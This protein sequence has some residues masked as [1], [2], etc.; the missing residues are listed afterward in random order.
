M[1][2]VGALGEL[3]FATLRCCHAIAIEMDFVLSARWLIRSQCGLWILCLIPSN[4]I[5]DKPGGTGPALELRSALHR[6]LILKNLFAVDRIDRQ[7]CILSVT[8]TFL[9]VVAQMVAWRSIS[10]GH[11]QCIA[12][13]SFFDEF[14]AFRSLRI[15]S[16]IIL[17]DAISLFAS[18]I[19][20]QRGGMSVC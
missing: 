2:R 18:G 8:D 4:D 7:F 11:R 9:L 20:S 12:L 13:E 15:H 10:P 1:L 14:S 6:M 5:K 17:Y 19:S 16:R 3:S